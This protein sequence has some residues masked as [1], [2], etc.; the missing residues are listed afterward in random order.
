MRNGNHIGEH[1]EDR[2]NAILSSLPLE[3]VQAVELPFVV[4]RRVAL[5]ATVTDATKQPL[6]RVAVTHF[7]TRAPLLRGWIFGGPAA[8]NTQAKGFVSALEKFSTD[9]LPLIIGGD[10]NTYLGSKGV[11]D[12][13]S[14]VAPRTECGKQPTHTSGFLLDHIFAEVPSTWPAQCVR[15]TS[16]FGSDHYPLLF[17]LK[18]AWPNHS[19]FDIRHSSFVN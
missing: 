8:R 14:Q 18:V 4:Q 9:A 5:I 10:L 1:A 12:T 17:S 11:I 13:L 16:T 3:D 19:S 15:A 6:L 2:G 7:D